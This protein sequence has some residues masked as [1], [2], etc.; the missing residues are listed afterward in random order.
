VNEELSRADA[1]LAE[2]KSASVRETGEPTW[3]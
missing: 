2:E 1:A 3:E